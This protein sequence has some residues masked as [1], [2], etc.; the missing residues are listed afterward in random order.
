MATEMVNLKVVLILTI[1]FTL[2]S[3]LGYFSLR[4]KLSP[5]MGYL[6][7]GFLIGPYSPGFVADKEVSEQ[8]A[9]IGVILMM[10]G[11]G[12]HFKWQ[13]LVKVK[14]IAIPGAIGQ[15]VLTT[16]ITAIIMHIFGWSWEAG[17]VFGI[18]IGVA[19]TVVLVR[20]LTSN[21]LIKTES[22]KIS[23]G[24]LIVEDVITVAAILLIPT[25]A[26]SLNG[27]E[28]S[29]SQLVGQFTLAIFKFFILAVIMLTAG[30]RF[31]TYILDKIQKT[32]SQ[33]LFS[34]AV[35][36]LTFVIATGS[37]ILFGTSIALGAFIAGMS[38]AQTNLR[39]EVNAT[40]TPLKDTFIVMFFISVGMIF[41]PM[42]VFEHFGLFLMTLSIILIVKPIIAFFITCILGYSSHIGV[43]IAVAL[44]QIGE[45]SFIMAEQA[46][47]FGI[48]PQVGYDIIVACALISL[49]LNP[50]LFK[51][52]HLG[53]KKSTA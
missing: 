16:I 12:L 33:E 3:I 9:E 35:L 29:S 36:S 23:V 31:V 21:N 42:A 11:V 43:T 40:A 5:I 2:A 45:F 14:Y 6:I 20:V 47:K 37:A 30:K 53:K 51:L 19:S 10:F 32:C 46:L 15:T 24:W 49:S 48:L 28:Y 41:N 4:L 13:D 52:L 34:L 27:Q 50:S 26:A 8:L 22:G 38:A 44:S 7:A 25:L 18:A 39:K 1:G 17:I